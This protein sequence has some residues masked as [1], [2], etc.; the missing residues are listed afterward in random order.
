MADFKATDLYISDHYLLQL[1]TIFF[2][3][4]NNDHVHGLYCGGNFQINTEVIGQLSFWN[5]NG[6]GI[7]LNCEWYIEVP[8]DS[9]IQISF[10]E[11]NL[12]SPNEYE[13]CSADY[14]SI[15]NAINDTDEDIATLPIM[16][17][18]CGTKLPSELLM[19][20]NRV[21]IFF[22]SNNQELNRGFKLIYQIK[23][24]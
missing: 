7:N 6:Y 3:G 22:H 13:V 1:S 14:L 11:F 2:L 4:N 20:G 18:E 21:L 5:P 23:K 16:A 17:K 9:L 15:R 19:R 8:K 24:E 10:T 12:E